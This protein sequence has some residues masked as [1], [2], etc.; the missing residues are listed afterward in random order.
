MLSNILKKLK[1]VFLFCHIF[2]TYLFKLTVTYKI[3]NVYAT[4]SSFEQIFQKLS[5]NC[6]NLTVD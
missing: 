5:L 6:F 2:D 1:L 4:K 3:S